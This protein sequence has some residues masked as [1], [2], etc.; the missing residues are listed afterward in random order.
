MRPAALFESARV[1]A[2]ALRA[3]PLRTLLSTTGVMIGVAAL[4]AAF[5]VTDGVAVWSRQLIMRE[6]SVQDVTIAPVTS[7][8]ANGRTVPVHGYPVFTIDDAAAARMEVPGVTAQVLTLSGDAPVE[9]LDRR[10]TVR[11][12]VS[13]AGLAEFSGLRVGA[14][15]FYS[16]AEVAHAAPVVVLGHHL[17]SEL[18]GNRDALWLVGRSVRV[19]G[20]PREVIGVLAP[21]T[22]GAETDLVA[23]A[24]LHGGI[25]L[26]DA[27][28]APRPP[29]LRLKARS[30]EAV[31]TL[32]GAAIDWL[33]ERYGRRVDKLRVDVANQQLENTRMGILLT[34][35]LLGML[36]GL[37]L[38]VGGIGIMN[39]LLAAVSERTREIGIRKAVGARARD[40]Q[41]QFL[42]ES[43]TV[44]GV[45]A[46]IGF[47]VGLALAF[48]GT[49][50]FRRLLGSDIHPVVRPMTALL[51]IL[52]SVTVGLVFGTYPARRAARLSPVDAIAR[53]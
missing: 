21:Q 13:T 25:E 41:A 44:T 6:S 30:I 7:V 10:A 49:A 3:N 38:A 48:G 32:R 4:V 14:G 9:H 40:I 12:T 26:L 46:A 35:L 28:G 51:A 18:A 29:T 33:A 22:T 50:L 34:K 16:A 37:I 42:V 24:P 19:G 47:V 31:D 27:T 5:A 43:V 45:G 8:T 15:R 39:V 23:F 53:E 36:V 20:E 2:D 17:A 52:S 11:L 1:G